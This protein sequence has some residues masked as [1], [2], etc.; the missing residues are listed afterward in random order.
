MP[1]LTLEEPGRRFSGVPAVAHG[2]G[3]KP[4]GREGRVHRVFALEGVSPREIR[5]DPCAAPAGPEA[6]GTMSGVSASATARRVSPN[7]ARGG[8][9]APERR[10]GCRRDHRE[11]PI[12][13]C[14]LAFTSGGKARADALTTPGRE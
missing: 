6:R 4:F 7:S 3:R 12:G 11:G 1:L 14:G 2:F 10:P 13:A 9:D 5:M 8:R